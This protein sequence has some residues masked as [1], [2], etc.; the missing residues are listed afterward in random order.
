MLH[1]DNSPCHTFH[2]VADFLTSKAIDVVPQPLY[3]PDLTSCDFFIFTK[4]KIVLKGRH[5]GT[6]ENT[7][8]SVTNTLKTILV[9]DLQSCY[10]KWEQCLQGNYFEG[11]NIDV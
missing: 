4:L 7:Q 2:F 6:L 10:Q 3:S 8:K 11:D 1:H 9:E 5:F